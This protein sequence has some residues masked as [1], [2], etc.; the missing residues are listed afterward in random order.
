[1]GR[2][3]NPAPRCEQV[4]FYKRHASG[5]KE[6]QMNHKRPS[7]WQSLT[8]P[9]RSAY[10]KYSA[11]QTQQAAYVPE[12][13]ELTQV[14]LLVRSAF[15]L[16]WADAFDYVKN[17]I[18]NDGDFIKFEDFME[19][20]VKRT[21]ESILEQQEKAAVPNGF[22][23]TGSSGYIKGGAARTYWASWAKAIDLPL[24]E[25]EEFTYLMECLVGNF[26]SGDGY[27]FGF[28]NMKGNL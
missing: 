26:L 14:D 16:E 2:E 8:M 25:Y 22:G 24:V 6:F 7:S 28:M 11:A 3:R 10:E 21:I 20:R 15:W 18:F 19:N 5:R 23:F 4:S 27:K 17:R 13:Y 12:G 1:M 9:T